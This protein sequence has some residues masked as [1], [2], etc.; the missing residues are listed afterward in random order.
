M[1][2]VPQPDGEA[3]LAV[4]VAVV[5]FFLVCVRSSR[6]GFVVLFSLATR[7]AFGRLAVVSFFF[8]FGSLIQRP[9][10]QNTF[11]FDVV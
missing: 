7:L 2:R 1:Y 3:F 10:F 9:L 4:V 6:G 8:R 11:V 5:S